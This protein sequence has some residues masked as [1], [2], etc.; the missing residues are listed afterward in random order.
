MET[1]AAQDT[2]TSGVFC[3]AALHADGDGRSRFAERAE[4]FHDSSV[5]TLDAAPTR[6]L[7]RRVVV[8]L[9]SGTL[10]FWLAANPDVALPATSG[11]RRLGGRPGLSLSDRRPGEAPGS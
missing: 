1:W 5:A 6:S 7:A 11:V 2:R 8:L 9:T 4:Y 10:W 3:H